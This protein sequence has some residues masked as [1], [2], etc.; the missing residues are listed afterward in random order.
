MVGVVGMADDL[1][2]LLV[3]GVDA[4]LRRYLRDVRDQALNPVAR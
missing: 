2:V 3:P 4:E 1:L